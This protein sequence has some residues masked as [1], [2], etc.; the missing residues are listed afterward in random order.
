MSEK[1]DEKAFKELGAHLTRTNIAVEWEEYTTQT[2]IQIDPQTKMMQEAK[3]NVVV[4]VLGVGADVNVIKKGQY[5]LLGG[6]GRLITLN[7]TTYGI[8]KEHMVDM[9]FDTKPTVDF[10]EGEAHGDILTEATQAQV[11]RFGKK[12]KF[13]A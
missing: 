5:A 3:L 8:V 4:K 1:N 13:Q 10:D 11:E 6:A 12:H 9:V 7:G 2:G